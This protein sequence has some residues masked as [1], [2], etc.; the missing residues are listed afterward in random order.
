MLKC[1]NVM[2]RPSI[3]LAVDE[4][5]ILNSYM[6]QIMSAFSSFHFRSNSALR[7]FITYFEH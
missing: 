1:L 2:P 6:V 3:H 7:Y 4:S 5:A